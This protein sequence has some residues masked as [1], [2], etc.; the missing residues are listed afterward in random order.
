[1]MLDLAAIA[2][3]IV[4]LKKAEEILSENARIVIE[5]KFAKTIGASGSKL[6]P[7]SKLETTEVG[8]VCSTAL[9]AFEKNMEQAS[10]VVLNMRKAALEVKGNYNPND[11]DSYFSTFTWRQFTSDELAGC[12]ATVMVVD[13]G[14]LIKDE[15]GAFSNLLASDLPIRVLA[16]R[17]EDLELEETA[18][19][20]IRQE[21]ASIAIAHRNT[22]VYQSVLVE[23]DR[24]FNG[25]LNGMN[26]L[27][28]SVFHV[29]LPNS[30]GTVNPLLWSSAAT[31]SRAFP[32]VSYSGMSEKR[33]GSRWDVKHNPQ[34]DKI[35]PEH[36]LQLADNK[37]LDTQFTYADFMSLEKRCH[38]EFLKVDASYWT[39]DLISV[40]SYL[41]LSSEDR[42]G[43]VPFIWMVSEGLTLYKVAVT[44]KV[45]MASLERADHWRYLQENGGVRNF[46]AD[47]ALENMGTSLKAD[48]QKEIETLKAEHQKELDGVRN[49]STDQAMEQLTS[50]LLDL[51]PAALMTSAPTS[52]ATTIT[53]APRVEKAAE[54]TASAPKEEAK[55]VLEAAEPWIETSLCTTC[56]ECTD[57]NDKLFNYDADKKA[58]L[59][60]AKAGTFAEIVQAAEMCPV[61]II[62]PGSPVN[63]NEP[64][65]DELIAKAEKFN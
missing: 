3:I 52:A 19:L 37:T 54:P 20:R 57:I 8:K 51:D 1:M 48:A 27:S 13:D 42:I 47:S 38:S 7:N 5:A 61:G 49:E 21:I 14:G 34:T 11:H 22:Y 18:D 46:H 36:Q 41:S 62:H 56:D 53:A 65:L 10:A 35:W 12:P 55:D 43:K 60:D 30:Q 40:A 45:A 23:P 50:M 26:I 17:S 59:A 4:E 63:P 28:P 39:D 58:F 16:V 33:W 64:G 32:S 31:E 29:L 9:K 6:F 15:L 24:T 44:W 2:N 25:M